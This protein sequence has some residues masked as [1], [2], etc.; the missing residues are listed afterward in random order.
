MPENNIPLGEIQQFKS[1]R[2]SVTDALRSAIILGDLDEGQL[3]SAPALAAALGVSATPVREA[4]MDLAREELVT[5]VKNK[6]FRVTV[7][8]GAALEEQTQVR[9]LLE[10]P[11]MRALAGRLPAG[12]LPGLRELAD[13]IADGARNGDLHSYLNGDRELHARLLEYTGN[14][15]LVEL[16][17]RLRGQ[18]RLKALRK[19]AESGRLVESA[20]EHHRLLDVLEAGDGEAAYALIVLH[21]GHASRLWS[22]GDEGPDNAGSGDG[23]VSLIDVVPS[24]AQVAT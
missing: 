21:I 22:T 15:R 13:R 5:T 8:T 24:P 17:T 9:Q 18:T 19:L 12:D 1:L 7:M 2:D 6:G 4:M 10:G 11:A 20:L 16:T 14:R 23:P 3:Y